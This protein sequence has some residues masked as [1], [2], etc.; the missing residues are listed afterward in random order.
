MKCAAARGS[1]GLDDGE[2]TNGRIIVI[3]EDAAVEHIAAFARLTGDELDNYLLAGWAH[4]VW[5]GKV[6]H[7]VNLC[8]YPDPPP[9]EAPDVDFPVEELEHR[10]PVTTESL[11]LVAK[12]AP[13]I[14]AT[15]SDETIRKHGKRWFESLTDAAAYQR[16][17]PRAIHSG[18]S[19]RWQGFTRTKQ[20]GARQPSR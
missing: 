2:P 13:A 7:A 4:S 17:A 8:L 10:R 3:L 18:R 19:P 11:A 1:G 15:V 14:L 5:T 9:L 20:P 6:E 12:H 16:R